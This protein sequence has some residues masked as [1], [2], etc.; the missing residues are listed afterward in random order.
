[1][2]RSHEWGDAMGL[3]DRTPTTAEEYALFPERFSNWGRWGSDDQRGTINLVT[4]AVTAA[5]ASLVREGR[6]VS[7]ALPIGPTRASVPSGFEHEMSVSAASSGDTLHMRFHG[8]SMTHLD[9]LCHMFTGPG[10]QLYNGAPS[11]MVDAEGAHAGSVDAF[12]SG[13]VTRGVLYDVPRFRDVP[14]VPLDAPVHGWELQDIAAATGI[15]PRAG[16]A[17]VIR[18]GAG[19]FYRATPQFGWGMAGQMPGV[20]ASAVE[21]LYETD[22]ALVVWDL[23]ESGGTGLP[24]RLRAD[25]EAIPMHEICIPFMGMPLVD[26]A[27]LEALAETCSELGRWEFLLTVAP[28]P[29][30]GGTGSPV[31]P[32]AV[33]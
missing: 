22:A 30:V 25:G 21:F 9:S 12:A 26:N 4:P 1:M 15:T 8:W 16:D 7:L 31:N 20:H 5:A 11:S 6:S 33:F 29:V 28:L 3:Q 27:D 10:G 13:I 17:V 24:S 19:E 2:L 18:S 23:L 32:L 14:H